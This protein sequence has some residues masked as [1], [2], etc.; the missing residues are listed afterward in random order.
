[1]L[2]KVL[3]PLALTGALVLAGC[4]DSNAP[5]GDKGG[6]D[7]V[8]VGFSVYDMQYEFFQKMEKGTREAVAAKGWEFKL[9]DEKSDENEMVT[10]AQA[11]IDQG[12]DVL[13]ISP[14]KPSALG[15]II[16]KAKAKGV[17]VI[18]DDIGGGGAPYDAIVISDNAGGGKLAAEYMAKQI[19][20]NGKTSKNVAS[21]TCEPS[22]VYAARRNAGFKEAIEGLGFKVVAELSGNS[23]AEEGY[24][25][26]KDIMA[27]NPDVAGVFSC[28]DPMGVAAANAVKDAGKNPVTDIVTVGFNAD[29]EALTAIK[30]GGLAATVAQ[31]PAAMGALTVKLAGQALSKEAITFGNAAER[32]VF[33]PVLLVTKDNV[34]TIK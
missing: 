14:F 30:G 15:P 33:N 24:K 7:K 13:I 32:E 1:M 2:K 5:S 29:P 9:H 8:V 27:K 31:D 3:V 17:P 11:L 12:V 18:V 19:A 20:A 21:I 23:K 25:V 4:S 16:A 26:M 10:G 6:D 28:N 34:A 22:A